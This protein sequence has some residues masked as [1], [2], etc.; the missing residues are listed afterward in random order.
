[1]PTVCDY[2]FPHILLSIG[3]T[4]VNICYKSKAVFGV[5]CVVYW[6]SEGDPFNQ[7]GRL[8]KFPTLWR[9]LQLRRIQLD[10]KQVSLGW[11]AGL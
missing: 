10:L 11:G 7:S 2:A 6:E 4:I 5:L 3:L 1:M 9:L 8:E